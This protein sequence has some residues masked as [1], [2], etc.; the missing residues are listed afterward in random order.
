VS[1]YRFGLRTQLVW[2]LALLLL[3]TALLTL[4][5]AWQASEQAKASTKADL[6]TLIS[7]LTRPPSFPLTEPVLAK[8]N[9]LTGYNF[10]L[11]R[12]ASPHLDD[13][14]E[15]NGYLYSAFELP[16]THPN[17]G[18]V[19]WVGYPTSRWRERQTEA[20]RGPVILGVAVVLAILVMLWL[21]SR[22]VV[23][24]QQVK[25][26]AK[27][28]VSDDESAHRQ[29]SPS[30][31]DELDDLKSALSETA[32][33][34]YSYQQQLQNAERL[35]VLGQ[36]SGGLAHQLRNA[37]T[38]AKLSVQL[39]LHDNPPDEESMHVALRQLQRMET[40]LQQFLQVGKPIAD[41]PMSVINLSD[42]VV[43]AVE[44]YAA[45]AKHLGITLTVDCRGNTPRRG[46]PNTLGHLV[47]NLIGN[48]LDAAGP[49]GQVQVTCLDNV[50]EVIDS[51]SGPAQQI[52][53][54]LFEPFVTAKPQGIGLGLAVAKQVAEAHGT[55]IEWFRREGRTVFRV[56]FSQAT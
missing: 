34:L 35:R 47:G 43:Q 25:Q 7:S 18:S 54:K 15:L 29:P 22:L 46:E 37:A 33:R 31:V 19:L 49:G 6:T 1:R 41:S 8:M 2:P 32:N 52:Q 27:L 12:T 36:F 55:S 11:E 30:S 16:E 50:L 40:M 51:G 48:A 3:L 21:S 56:N 38:A 26:Q 45:Q 9:G 20:V 17:F 10:Q 28:L 53:A 23:R 4:W 42:V 5:S 44:S 14:K 39:S 13:G 24:I